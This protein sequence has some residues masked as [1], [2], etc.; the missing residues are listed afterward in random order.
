MSVTKNQMVELFIE[1]IT[2][3]GN[4]VGRYQGQAI[5]VPLTAPGERVQVQIAKV[6]KQYA[7]GILRQVLEPAACRIEQDCPVYRSCGGCQLRHITYEEELCQ[8][9]QMVADCFARIGKI[10]AEMLPILPSPQTEHYRNKVQF[11]VQEDSQGK[12]Q[13]GFFAPRSHRLVA[14]QNCLL[15][16]TLLNEIAQ[17]C[18]VLM[19]KY[20]IP[21]Y[22]EQTHKGL[23]RHIYLRQGYHS[24][25]VLLCLVINGTN[26]PSGS[27]FCA[28]IQQKFPE[29]CSIVL[30]INQQKTNVITGTKSVC[31]VGKE[32]IQDN[33][34]E[35]PVQIGPLSFYQ[36]NTPAAE[37][38]YH[39]AADFAQLKPTDV[40]LDLYCGMGT[41]GLSM[42]RQCKQLI[43]VEVIPE[44]VESAWN[45]AKAMNA[46][47]VRFLCADAGTAA[48]QLAKE[49]LQ[50]NVIVLDPPRKGCDEA[51]LNAVVEMAPERIVM[52]SCNPATAARDVAILCGKGYVAQKIQ[53]ADLF[54]RTKHIETIVQ[55]SR[56]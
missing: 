43:G 35:V 31:L 22:N 33:M 51:T 23:V 19:E 49:G 55:L 50:P 44:A 52:I 4:G 53:A 38:L 17:Y 48:T 42:Y 25:Q 1:G 16:P 7:Y 32:Y 39:V 24:G 54:P 20:H 21:A 2:S 18:C 56:V 9:Q 40:L 45:N 41:I 14:A 8:K 37:Q 11:P 3:E 27:K 26:L 6:A 28:D 5:F 29:V 34:C 47:N 36:V 10:T 15:Q 12:P 13:I 30:N 46:E